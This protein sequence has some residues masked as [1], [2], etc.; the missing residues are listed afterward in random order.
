MPTIT[1][2]LKVLDC[3]DKLGLREN[4]LHSRSGENVQ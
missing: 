1:L 3:F 4:T 2:S